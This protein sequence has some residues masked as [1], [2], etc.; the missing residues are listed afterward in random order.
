MYDSTNSQLK[1]MGEIVV[2]RAR[3]IFCDCQAEDDFCIQHIS[4]TIVVFGGTNRLI[5]DPITGF[6]ADR[7]YCTKRFLD[8]FNSLY[9]YTME[10]S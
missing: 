2:E 7:E 3:D 8:T 4:G 5:F 9:K 1:E 10:Q 6:R